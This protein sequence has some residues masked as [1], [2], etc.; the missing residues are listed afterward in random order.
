MAI[1]I[2]LLSA[3]GL[4]LAQEDTANDQDIEENAGPPWPGPIRRH[5]DPRH[6]RTTPWAA[7]DDD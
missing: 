7:Q 6:T 3:G 2:G 5:L 4:A 1:V